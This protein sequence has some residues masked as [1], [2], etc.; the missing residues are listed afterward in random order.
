M[1]AGMVAWE[2]GCNACMTRS[3]AKLKPQPASDNFL[4]ADQLAP[5]LF[6]SESFALQAKKVAD[7]LFSDERWADMYADEGRPARSPKV[8][9]LAL[10]LQQHRNLSDRGMEHS[11][12]FDLEIKAALG[13]PWD[14]PGI[15]KSAYGEFRKRLMKYGRECEAFNAFNQMLVEKGWV[16]KDEAVIVDAC[17]LEADASTPNPRLLI[18]K[19]TRRILKDLEK[20]RPE[21]YEDLK[22]KITLRSD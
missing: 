16:K 1:I 14:H 5:G 17:H 3:A 18:R 6:S 8:M 2:N 9:T 19:G 21:L 4:S 15:P 20:E 11:T 12:R 10:I 7:A 13:L 22:E